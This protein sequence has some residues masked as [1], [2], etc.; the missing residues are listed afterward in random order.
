MDTTTPLMRFFDLLVDRG[1]Q[2]KWLADQA[3]MTRAAISHVRNGHTVRPHPSTQAA[4]EEACK[5]PEGTIAR[6]MDGTLTP[7]EAVALYGT[8]DEPVT[9][10][11]TRLQLR[12]LTGEVERTQDRTDEVNRKVDALEA[13]VQR[14]RDDQAAFRVHTDDVDRST[15][16][17]A[18][19]FAGRL[20][21]AERQL[22]ALSEL[23]GR[24]EDLLQRLEG[25]Q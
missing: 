12:M 15:R 14:I 8:A 5:M 11:G 16:S 7:E 6:V 13:A 22:E 20:D 1:V 2:L 19:D 25:R 24:L 10:E 18:D 9:P 21:A 23:Q 3:G 17:H 4:I